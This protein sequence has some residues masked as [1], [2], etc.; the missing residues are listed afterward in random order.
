MNRGDSCRRKGGRNGEKSKVEG[1]HFFTLCSDHI[2]FNPSQSTPIDSLPAKAYNLT[3]PQRWKRYRRSGIFYYNRDTRQCH[4]R[5]RFESRGRLFFKALV[6]HFWMTKYAPIIIIWCIER[7]FYKRI[8]W[9]PVSGVFTNA[10]ITWHSTYLYL[11]ELMKEN[12]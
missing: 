5:I 1:E 4:I 8:A 12:W 7:G 2:D 9:S 3:W 10:L 6:K 11:G